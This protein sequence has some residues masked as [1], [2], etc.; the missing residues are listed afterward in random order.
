[1]PFYS[2]Q[3]PTS[4]NAT[5]LQGRAVAATGPTGGQV[6]TWDGSSWAPLAGTTG[7]TG[8]AGVDGRFIYSGST[9]PSSGLGR[10]GDYFI[11]FN[12]G[13]LYGPKVSNSWGGGLLLQSGP[14]GPTGATG[15][16]AT[17]PTGAG[18]T[19][20]TGSVGATGASIT[21]PTGAASN[22][23]GPTGATGA[24]VTG[25][26]GIGP[27]GPT[28]S[29]TTLS[30]GSVSI[31]SI[32]SAS[33]SGPAGA[34]VL[35]LVLPFG[36]TGVTGSTG[37]VGVT[38]QL[39]IGSVD[40]ASPAA[41]GLVNVSPGNYLLNFSIP[42]G[43]TGAASNVTGPTGAASNVTGPTGAA[44]NVTGPAGA[45]GATGASVTGPT[46]AAS[47]AIGPTG[48]TGAAATG[49]TGVAGP[50]GPGGGG[51][52][53]YTLPE[54]SSSVLGG[55]KVGSGLSIAS[56]V[57]SATGGGGSANI[58]E[59]ATASAFPAVGS[60]GTIYHAIDA[61][62]IYFWDA[63]GGV[64]VEAGPSGGGGGGG[65]GVTSVVEAATYAALPSPGAAATIYVVRST[66]QIYRFDTGTSAYFELSSNESIDSLLRS[67]FR[68]GPPTAVSAVA[69]NAQ[70]TVSW[71]APTGVIAQ[72]PITNYTVEHTL[73]G[74]S[75]QTFSTGSTATSYTA[76]SLQNGGS[77]VFRVRAENILG[78]GVF[79]AA[80]A[81]VTPTA[82][83][84]DPSF[85]SVSLLL[86]MEGAT[87]VDSSA[88]GLAVTAYEGTEG[89][90]PTNPFLVTTEKKFGDKSF[91]GNGAAYGVTA[92]T[93]TSPA[94]GF[95][96]GDFC[97]EG[98]SYTSNAYSD[99]QYLFY[100]PSGVFVAIQG[101]DGYPQLR[102]NNGSWQYSDAFEVPHGQWNYIAVSRTSGQL[103][104]YVNGTRVFTAADSRN[105][106]ASDKFYTAIN[107]NG[108]VDEIRVTK[109]SD[110]GYTGSTITVPTAA[111]P[112]NS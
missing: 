54:A 35:S 95:G 109:G 106:G 50:T 49:P 101:V 63:T 79:S 18:S 6:L 83:G 40:N 13:V 16:G 82:G 86:H 51:S 111:F 84:N 81:A 70:A 34:Q 52:G 22:V 92:V 87:L 3:S 4:G 53:S 42:V 100:L 9:G 76:T 85:A 24:S 28:G 91:S 48:P 96:T 62:R 80:S 30:V 97:I 99:L 20:A 90:A 23:T 77:Y 39:A 57:L 37:P 64:Y 59:A 19:G 67:L 33:L 110:R 60:V 36:P 38:P 46:G 32:A 11:D 1:M 12:A 102:I 44:S 103:S 47:T 56:G 68:P 105:Y 27:T 65:G 98:W 21:G 74:G 108:F 5:Q 10:S 25:P 78:A 41:A 73:A 58:V 29:P 43:P 17:G 88:N 15:A 112:N 104:A 7:P 71:T 14:Q 55:I 45:T 94:L 8:A 66:S 72:A 93:Q 69:G 61:K 31:G 107:L 2:I 75:P 89:T 26:T